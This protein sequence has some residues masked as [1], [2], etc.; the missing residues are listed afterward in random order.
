L[1]GALLIA[2]TLLALD[3]TA[4]YLHLPKENST[5]VV[6]YTTQWC[7]YCNALHNVLRQHNIPFKEYDTEKS[8]Q[9]IMGF[10]ALRGR[11]VPVSMIGEEIIYG[12]DGQKVTDALVDAGYEISIHW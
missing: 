8:I 9:G 6:I 2:L 3:R 11:R 5:A 4:A 7:P 10:W 1:Y 12:Y